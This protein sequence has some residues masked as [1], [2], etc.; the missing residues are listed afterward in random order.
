M[1]RVEYISG[2]I[3]EQQFTEDGGAI[4][5]DPSVVGEVFIVC[6]MNYE[7][8]TNSNIYSSAEDVTLSLL[9]ESTGVSIRTEDGYVSVFVDT[10]EAAAVLDA[11]RNID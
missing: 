7:P 8:D 9:E 4:A 3:P 10:A 2:E 1:L 5:P 6:V 11:L